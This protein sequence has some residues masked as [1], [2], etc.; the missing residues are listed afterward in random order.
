MI[1]F[2]QDLPKDA[3]ES[4][5]EPIIVP[6][7]QLS[8][9]AIAGLIDEFVTRAGTDYGDVEVSLAAKRAQV[10]RQ[11]QRG[12]VVITFDPNEGSCNLVSLD[13]AKGL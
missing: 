11:L 1:D 6:F 4:E 7:A 12:E 10:L 13:D 9:Y 5:G 3:S 2:D 8:E